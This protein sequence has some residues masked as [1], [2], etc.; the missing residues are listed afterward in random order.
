MDCGELIPREQTKGTKNIYSRHGIE[1]TPSSDEYAAAK[2]LLMQYS[3]ST[4]ERD[5]PSRNR[6][7][8]VVNSLCPCLCLIM[9]LV[10]QPRERSRKRHKSSRS[11]KRSRSRSRSSDSS[12]ADS[13]DRDDSSDDDHR[14]SSSASSSSS[15]TPSASSSSSSLTEAAPMS[16]SA[17][18]SAI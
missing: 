3:A 17:I 5:Y 8:K 13:S 9:I 11:K 16:L 7:R 2:A 10:M 15:S 4:A 6:S 12:G 14:D 18:L 1:S